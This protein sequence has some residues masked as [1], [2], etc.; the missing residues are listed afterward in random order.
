[1]G[2]VCRER[3][4]H[5][6][7]GRRQLGRNPRLV[8]GGRGKRAGTPPSAA[9]KILVGQS[10]TDSLRQPHA[11]STGPPRANPQDRKMRPR[12]LFFFVWSAVF[13]A[14]LGADVVNGDEWK[15]A[16]AEWSVCKTTDECI[17]EDVVCG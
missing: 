8:S 2:L 9:R 3:P 14:R 4:A 16:H 5:P 7:G 13:A 11:R 12:M 1:M 15:S 17:M 6:H 10:G